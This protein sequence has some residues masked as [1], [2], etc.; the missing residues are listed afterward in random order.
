MVH[1]QWP[2]EAVVEL[3]GTIRMRGVVTDE[4]KLREL[5]G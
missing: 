4:G 5:P 1:D 2:T 3:P